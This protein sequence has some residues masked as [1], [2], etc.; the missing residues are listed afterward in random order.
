MATR[1]R[2]SDRDARQAGKM[3]ADTGQRAGGHPRHPAPHLRPHRRP[4]AHGRVEPR[5]RARRVGGRRHGAGGRCTVRGPQQGWAVPVVPLVAARP[6]PH[7]RPW[8]GVRLRHRGGGR[9]STVWRYQFAP[10]HDGT[11][12][13][14]SY[15][16]R[17]L[18]AW[19]RLID[20]PANRHRELQ[21]AMRHTLGKL[22]TAAEAATD[23]AG[24]P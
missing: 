17:W 20:V 18:P 4:P 13:T 11:L 14:E 6:G 1:S 21:E 8:P 2:G 15:E 22:K 3:V 16:V 10:V 7:R 23:P 24:P 12:V 5:V 9:E 19:A